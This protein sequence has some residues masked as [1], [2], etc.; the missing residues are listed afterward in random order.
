MYLPGRLD[1]EGTGK[2]VEAEIKAAFEAAAATDPWFDEHPL[3]YEWRCDIVPAE[4][5]ADHPL[6]VATLD[7]GA[8]LGR[9]GKP[10]GLDSWHDAATFT[11]RGTPTFSYG[12]DALA[13]AHTIDEWIVEDEL[14]D[15]AAVYA[16]AAMR[17]CGV[18]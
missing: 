8:G 16:L 1:A 14:V 7:A 5:P 10:G 17:W 11:L 9:A 18:A 15:A 4:M 3:A 6:V 2:A 12:P 13:T